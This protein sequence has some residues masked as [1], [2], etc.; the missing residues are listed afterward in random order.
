[1][2]ISDTCCVLNFGAYSKDDHT[3]FVYSAHLI[4]L[5]CVKCDDGIY[6]IICAVLCVMI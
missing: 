6:W 4:Y 3:L 2:A 1:M 5:N